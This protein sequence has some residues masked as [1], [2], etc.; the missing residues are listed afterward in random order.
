MER[1][2]GV[3][4]LAGLSLSLLG[5]GPSFWKAALDTAG[6]IQEESAEAQ[7]AATDELDKLGHLLCNGR[8]VRYGV[9]VQAV[10][11]LRAEVAKGTAGAD[12]KLSLAEDA[13]TTEKAL[14]D[15]ACELAR[16]VDASIG[17]APTATPSV[18]APTVP[19]PVTAPTGGPA[20][21]SRVSAPMPTAALPVGVPSPTPPVVVPPVPE[22]R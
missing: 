11:D 3:A 20:N 1:R 7:K 4:L 8:A 22:V 10:L 19:P 14:F 5:C 13:A 17:K 15:G 21:P 6:K 16:K 18:T 12:A 9:K 2:T